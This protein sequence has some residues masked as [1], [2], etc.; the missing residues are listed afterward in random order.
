M[1]N[2]EKSEEEDSKN[3]EEFDFLP[4]PILLIP[5][6]KSA[7]FSQSLDTTAKSKSKTDSIKIEENTIKVYF[8]EEPIYKII[9]YT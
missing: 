4:K 6:R 7:I 3:I 2:D 8:F 9:S 5:G 1:H